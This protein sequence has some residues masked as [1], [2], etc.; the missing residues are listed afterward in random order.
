M[1]VVYLEDKRIVCGEA[2][3]PGTAMRKTITECGC[4]FD[5]QQF[6][7]HYVLQKKLSRRSCS[8]GRCL[9]MNMFGMEQVFI[10]GSC[11]V[12]RVHLDFLTG[13]RHS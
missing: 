13:K 5:A 12:F 6:H 10:S 7:F 11:F 1:F 8:L 4:V 9:Q 2:P 3:A